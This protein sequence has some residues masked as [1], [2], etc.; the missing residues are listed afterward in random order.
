LLLWRNDVKGVPPLELLTFGPK[1]VQVTG[2]SRQK[3]A[4]NKG[5]GWK[6]PARDLKGFAIQVIP[7]T[8]RP[9]AP[10]KFSGLARRSA[11]V[12]PICPRHLENIGSSGASLEE[13]KKG[14]KPISA[15]SDDLE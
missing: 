9:A 14:L 10:R 8:F 13:P 5:L 11:R 12:R 4:E 6:W 3:N 7:S 2:W 15:T 1:K